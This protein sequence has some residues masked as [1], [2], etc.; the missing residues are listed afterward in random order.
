MSRVVQ[1]R[2]NAATGTVV[3]VVDN[4]DGEFDSGDVGWFNVCVDHGSVVSHETRAL[5]T[6]FA[7]VPTE[8]CRDCYAAVPAG[9]L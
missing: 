8:W 9:V 1:E 3:Q 5:A 4:R 2:R 6:A 7:A